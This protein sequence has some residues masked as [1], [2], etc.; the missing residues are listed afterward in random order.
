M[1]PGRLEEDRRAAVLGDAGDL[2][3]VEV[4]DVPVLPLDIG[5]GHERRA[6]QRL[7]GQLQHARLLRVRQQVDIAGVHVD[8]GRQ[9]GRDGVLQAARIGVFGDVAGLGERQQHRGH[10]GDFA[11]RLAAGVDVGEVHGGLPACMRPR[12]SISYS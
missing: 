8:G 11:A 4:G 7:L 6:A 9:A 5:P 10:A 3:P 2:P 1:Q 12:F